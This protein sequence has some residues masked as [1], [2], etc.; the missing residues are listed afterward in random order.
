MNPNV[1]RDLIIGGAVVVFGLGLLGFALFAADDNFRA[2]R[3]AVAAAAIGFIVGGY[4]PLRHAAGPQWRPQGRLQYLSVA[5]VLLPLFVAAL[6]ALVAVGPE[7][8]AVTLDVPL[9]VSE[10]VERWIRSGIFYSV[11]GAGAVA[12]FGASMISLHRGVPSLG[13]TAFIAIV[14]PLVGVMLWVA[15]EIQRRTVPPHP[16]VLHL[17]GPTFTYRPAER[18]E[19]LAPVLG[20]HDVAPPSLAGVE[21]DIV[22]MHMALD[23]TGNRVFRPF[24]VLDRFR[25]EL[26]FARRRGKT[27]A[28]FAVNF[29]A[30]HRTVFR[31]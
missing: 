14:A 30:Q 26:Q 3:W 29:D 5:A 31:N 10:R 27:G 15:I 22:W 12:L 8:T 18:G 9:P 25:I 20:V 21:V 19:A 7:G 24:P 6:W 1:R 4:V 16:P 13:R 11:F 17:V 2:P 28:R 23:V